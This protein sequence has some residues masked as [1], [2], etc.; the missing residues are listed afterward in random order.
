[1]FRDLIIRN[2]PPHR[3]SKGWFSFKCPICN[4]YKFRAGFNF[5]DDFVKY[6]CWNC[7]EQARHHEDWEKMSGKMRHVLSFF[8]LNKQAIDDELGRKFFVN[9]GKPKEN[10]S[11]IKTEV[12]IYN[13]PEIPLPP[14]SYKVSQ[15]PPDDIWKT[16]AVEYLNSRGLDPD[17]HEYYLSTDK[18]FRERLIIPY[19]KD[20]KVIYWQAR[21]F[22]DNNKVR[23]INPDAD[24]DMIVFGYDKL[25]DYSVKRMFWSEGVTDGLSIDGGALLGSSLSRTK[26]EL[27]K[28]YDK[29]HIFIV[30]ADENGYKLGMNAIKNGYPITHLTAISDDANKSTQRFGRLWTVNDLMK[31]IKTGLAAQVFL[32]THCKDHS[33]KKRE[34]KPKC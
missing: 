22:D 24:K 32:E 30:D 16:V 18:D 15:A 28:R 11:T 33:K 21:H 29:E 26:L 3:E 34:Y 5:G 17:K 1:M 6:N 27:L 4:D 8:G 7:A 9:A 12:F 14:N 19:F 25:T 31:N 23:Y 13:P 20:G 10:V 2:L